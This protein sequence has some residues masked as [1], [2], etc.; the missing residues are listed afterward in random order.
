MLVCEYATVDE[1]LH[2]MHVDSDAH[3]GVSSGVLLVADDSKEQMVR[4]DAV[5]AGP[6]CF[7]SGEIY[8]RIQFVRYADFHKMYS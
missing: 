5:A 7:L 8:Y 4:R 3:K 6:H 2:L 1:L